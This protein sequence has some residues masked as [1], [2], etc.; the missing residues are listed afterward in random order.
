MHRLFS[1]IALTIAVALSAHAQTIDESGWAITYD[2]NSKTIAISKDGK[3]ILS[4][5][6]AAAHYAVGSGSTTEATSNTAEY[7]GM[8]SEA[9]SDEFGSGTR[10]TFTYALADGVEMQ[11][12]FAFYATLPYFITHLTLDGKGNTLKSNFLS[13]ISTETTATFLP[14]GNEKTANRMLYVPFDNDAWVSYQ[15]MICN[16]D[17]DGNP[18]ET[19]AYSVNAIYNG[20][21]RQGLVAGAVDHDTWKSIVHAKADNYTDILEFN[22]RSGYVDYWSH[23]NGLP[24][25]SVVGETVSSARFMMGMFD[26]WRDGLETFAQ[27]CQKVAPGW[28]WKGSKPVGWNS[29]GVMQTKLSYA[30]A[31]D[32]ANFI[33]DSLRVHSFEDADGKVVMSLDSYWNNNLTDADIQNFVAYCN[34]HNMIPGLYTSPFSDWNSDSTHAITGT[35]KYV[36]KDRWLRANGEF[37]NVDGAYCNDPTHSATKIEIVFNLNR[38][39]RWGI[40]YLKM[41]FLSNGAIEA[42]S[43]YDKNVHTG[44]QAYN[45]GMAFF[46]QKV[47]EIMGDDV[48]LDLSIA[49]LFPYQYAHGRRISCDAFGSISQTKYMMN[50]LSYG[51]W[52]DK[53]YF[54]ND[55]DHLVLNNG[56]SDGVRRARITSGVI[57]GAYLTGDNFS[58]QVSAGRPAMERNWATKF[59]TNEDINVI[60]RT[61]SSFR[62]VTGISSSGTG[63]ENFFQN[64]D[65]LYY[66]FVVMNYETSVNAASMTFDKLGIDPTATGTIKE[67]W[68]GQTVTPTATAIPYN[69]PGRDARVYRIEKKNQTSGIHELTQPAM[70]TISYTNCRVTAKAPSGIRQITVSDMTGKVVL[71]TDAATADLGGLACGVYIVNAQ[72]GDH[73]VATLKVLR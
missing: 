59:L 41:D 34:K 18:R 43:W 5:V 4:G 47:K 69:C 52:L 8:S 20:E 44:L 50:S 70:P 14:T 72:S 23:S 26:D 64:E 1:F 10:Y 30:G 48:Y 22:L 45:Q 42:D 57:C 17:G 56:E 27:A 6:Y 68:T 66:Y 13:P 73:K 28:E 53:L 60:P 3:A 19:N 54:C 21:T 25:G 51:W 12:Q 32:V 7:K 65:S 33:N 31:I 29:W 39:K 36:A 49:P 55:P 2:D 63:A 37:V 62:P 71:T 61:C 16:R 67:L 38:F 15:S 58:D 40:K 35:S 9:V 11:Q 46:K 24:H